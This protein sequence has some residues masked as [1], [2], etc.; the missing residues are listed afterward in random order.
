MSDTGVYEP[1]K[2]G[3]VTAIK[4]Y[5]NG[6][7]PMAVLAFAFGGSVEIQWNIVEE[8]EK[9]AAG[10]NGYT[11]MYDERTTEYGRTFESFIKEKENE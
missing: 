4:I 6:V 2:D 8:R 7:Y 10:I 11:L 5:N 3:S 1:L 9:Y